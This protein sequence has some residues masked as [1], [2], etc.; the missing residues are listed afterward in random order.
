MKSLIPICLL[1]VG[2][3][4][5]A[6]PTQINYQGRLTDGDGNPAS[7]SKIFGLKIYDAASGGNELYSETIGSIVVDDNGIYNF[8]FG[9]NGSSVVAANEVIATTDGSTQVFNSTLNEL[10]LDGSVAITDGTYTWSQSGGSSHPSEFTASVTVGTG[11]ISAIYLTGAPAS[12][13]D[14]A[15]S[16]DYAESGIS[17][18]LSSGGAH[19]LELTVDASIQTP[20]EKVL[21]VPFAQVANSVTSPTVEEQ[22][23]VYMSG[24]IYGSGGPR[25]LPR[26]E[27][28]GGAGGDTWILH[29]SSDFSKVSI[30]SLSAK[31][32]EIFLVNG[33][34][35]YAFGRVRLYGRDINSG[36]DVL[37]ASVSTNDNTE[38]QVFEDSDLIELDWSRYSYYLSC[39]VGSSSV[40][41]DSGADVEWVRVKFRVEK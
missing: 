8:Q 35:N 19:W 2:Q 12:G 5:L 16:Y 6:V 39:Q 23:V 33:G 38:F 20:R 29:L 15:A 28:Y 24:W 7:G 25:T 26:S 3:F 32:R 37:L 36:S 27:T 30:L 41:H 40:N 22:E 10:P 13:T 31:M 9:A 11:A 34:T 14:V 17:G 18:A 1:A 21:S 4:A